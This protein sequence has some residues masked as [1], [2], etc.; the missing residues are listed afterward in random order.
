MWWEIHAYN[1]STEEKGQWLKAI[2]GSTMS[3]WPAWLWKAY[4]KRANF[5]FKKNKLIYSLYSWCKENNLLY[6]WLKTQ[7]SLR[8]INSEL[9]SRLVLWEYLKYL[10]LG[11]FS[12]NWA[13]RFFIFIIKIYFSICFFLYQPQFPLLLILPSP[14][15]PC[16]I[17]LNSLPEGLLELCEISFIFLMQSSAIDVWNCKV[18]PLHSYV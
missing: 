12:F 4:L 15:F 2:L 6:S 13:G 10:E 5:V 8:E 7:H 16:P 18:G 17:H 1:L 9:Y 11:V 3:F 14:T